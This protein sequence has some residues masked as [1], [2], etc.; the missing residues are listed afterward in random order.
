MNKPSA[1]DELTSV[2][3]VPGNR[4][5][6]FPKAAHTE[7]SAVCLDLEDAVPKDAAAKEAARSAAGAAL[8]AFHR[9]MVLIRVN[10]GESGWLELDL[11][12]VVRG[13]LD[14]IVLPK[15]ERA[16]DIER[17]DHY[18]TYLERTS[19]L[20]PDA[21]WIVPIIESAH[22]LTNAARLLPVSGRVRAALF[23][24]EDFMNDLGI[25]RERESYQL[26]LARATFV[27]SCRAAGIAPLD[28]PDPDF[29][30]LDW[31]QLDSRRSRELGYLARFCIHPGQIPIAN[32]CYR[33]SSQEIAQARR[34]LTAFD[35]AKAQGRGT[36]SLD[37]R[38]I[39]E[40]VAE[41]ARRL[42]RRAGVSASVDRDN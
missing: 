33:P 4:P 6:M 14:G 16:E 17:L 1:A 9:Q 35:E 30:D 29:R 20:A 13:G 26:D 34:V 28:G 11:Q 15:V 7:A 2:V 27:V 12:A 19:R 36:T 32:E 10:P 41:R 25:A 3:F 24:A 22:G 37:G 5:D 8:D 42:L 21:I 39:D 31:F 38:M 23:G 18:L 40:P